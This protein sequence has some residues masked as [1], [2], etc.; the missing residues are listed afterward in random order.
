MSAIAKESI[1]LSTLPSVQ[2]ADR[3]QLPDTSGI[4]FAIT[5]DNEVPYIESLRNILQRW[6]TL[7]ISSPA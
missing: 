1:N 3:R 5:V 4:Y 2:L 6:L 7:T